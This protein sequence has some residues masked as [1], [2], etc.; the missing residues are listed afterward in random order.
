MVLKRGSKGDD[1]L[2][3][4]KGLASL[5]YDVGTPDG[6]F[7]GKT[8]D[9]VEDFQDSVDLTSDGIFGNGS[10][11]AYNAKVAA[12]FQFAVV[13]QPDPP[14][15]PEA[16]RNKWVTVPCHVAGGG[17]GNT[18]LRDDAAVTF[19]AMY[20]EVGAL[21][22]KLSSAGGKRPLSAGGGKAQSKTSMHY[23]GR[24]H[25]MALPAGMQNPLTDSAVVCKRDESLPFGGD[26]HWTVWLRTDNPAVPE[27]TLQGVQ[28]STVS[29]KTQLKLVPVTGRF[30]NFTE[31]AAKHGWVGIGGRKFFFQGG[32][33][34]GAEWWHFQWQEGLVQGQTTFG[35][36]LLRLYSPQECKALAWWDEVKDA[37]FGEDFN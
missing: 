21:G 22:G 9:A 29:G 5:G 14:A 15:V 36:E 12:D 11:A 35:S 34:A 1:V 20:D 10:M 24:A 7:G 25:D 16:G 2:K 30:F 18:T 13:V 19:K 37:V 6:V 28:C 26:R 33:Y 23:L 32:T 8:E 4:Q 31:L 17:F 27:V 3:L